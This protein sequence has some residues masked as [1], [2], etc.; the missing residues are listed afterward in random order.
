MRIP[1]STFKWA[2][3]GVGCF[4]I[5]WFYEGEK[6]YKNLCKQ[7]DELIED[8]RIS[9]LEGT[10]ALERTQ[11]CLEDLQE[12]IENSGLLS[13]EQKSELESLKKT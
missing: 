9:I 1:K 7:K 10:M 12:A 13:E 5:G 8:Q 11:K 4:L 6:N 2:L 3:R